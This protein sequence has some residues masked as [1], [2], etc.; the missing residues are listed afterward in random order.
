MTDKLERQSY[1]KSALLVLFVAI[2]VWAP[3]S[4]PDFW[5][6]LTIGRWILHNKAVPTTEHWNFFAIGQPFRAY[7]WLFEGLFAFVDLKVGHWGLALSHLLTIITLAFVVFGVYRKLS[8][9]SLIGAVLT[10]AVMLGS[11]GHASFRPQLIAWTCFVLTLYYSLVMQKQCSKIKCL[12]LFLVMLLWANTNITP[13]LGLICPVLI[14]PYRRNGRSA[15]LCL[16]V[17]F[18]GTLCTPYLGGEWL[19]FLSKMDHPLK[20]SEISEFHRASFD[21]PQV[22]PLVVAWVLLLVMAVRGRSH[23]SRLIPLVLFFTLASIIAVKF[24]PYAFL[25]L[26]FVF[27]MLLAEQK[28]SKDKLYLGV[29]E[30]IKLLDKARLVLFCLPLLLAAAIKIPSIMSQPLNLSWVPARAFDAVQNQKLPEPYLVT[31]DIGGY[32]M[33]RF[34]DEAGNVSTQ[35]P[36]DGRTNVNPVQIW[37]AYREAYD[38]GDNWSRFIELTKA[39]TIIWRRES[40]FVELLRSSGKWREVYDDGNDKH[41]YVVLTAIDQ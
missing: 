14:W 9:S 19:T 24:L 37:E 1:L 18:A 10:A 34:S 25:A 35:I 23:C 30:L 27:A 32:L 40:K 13:V 36:I 20:L 16:L 4:S 12:K 29:V 15:G 8:S 31:F 21:F 41:G 5:W 6:H 22:G 3:L 11:W 7:S 28:D 38:G 2:I 17:I 39:R 33:Y 26:G